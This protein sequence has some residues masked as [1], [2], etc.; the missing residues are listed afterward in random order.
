[1]VGH[2]KQIVPLP[3]DKRQPLLTSW[4][5]LI[6]NRSC[7][8]M[9]APD[10]SAEAPIHPFLRQRLS[11]AFKGNISRFAEAC[12]STPSMASKWIS[13]DPRRR[14][15]PSSASCKKIARGLRINPDYVLQLA[16][17]REGETAPGDMDP[18]LAAFLT[19]VEAGW[20]AMDEAARDMAERTAKAL[21]H[22]PPV[23]RRHVTD[24]PDEFGRAKMEANDQVSKPRYASWNRPSRSVKS[25][26]LEVGFQPA[27]T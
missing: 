8:A 4:P 25:A 23:Q 16:G 26:I 24:R 3:N 6:D 12:D 18:R 15:T 7:P 11:D 17:H 1:M 27:Y 9:T 2:D 19:D 14:V 20:R 13:D 10:P 22:V 5:V 21:F